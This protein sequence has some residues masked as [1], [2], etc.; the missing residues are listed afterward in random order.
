[1]GSNRQLLGDVNGDGRADAVVY[2]GSNGSWYVSRSTGSAF[3]AFSRW[4]NGHGV[5]SSNQ[6]LADVTGDSRAD[7]TAFFK[8][9]GSW[10]VSPS[11][12]TSFAGFSRWI[13]G[14]GAG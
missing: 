8:R 2:F 6:L 13:T 3:G 1:V 14:H 4:I 11:T 5:R 10:Y 12:G 9:D 7:A